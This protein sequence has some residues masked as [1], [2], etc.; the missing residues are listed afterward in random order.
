MISCRTSSNRCLSR[1]SFAPAMLVSLTDG[2]VSG[3]EEAPYTVLSVFA[4][5]L[6][7]E[8]VVTMQLTFQRFWGL[9]YSDF[10]ITS[11][12]FCGSPP[13]LTYRRVGFERAE[14]EGRYWIWMGARLLA[15][16]VI[17]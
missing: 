11:V 8:P 17:D 2:R 16:V 9:K 1:M 6:S 12:T 15:A 10:S 14:M 5:H 7:T 4:A 3:I 13:S